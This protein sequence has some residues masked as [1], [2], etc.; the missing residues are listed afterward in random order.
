MSVPQKKCRYFTAFSVSQLDTMILACFYDSHESWFVCAKCLVE[1]VI[2][3]GFADAYAA[4]GNAAY[5]PV[6]KLVPN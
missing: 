2:Y 4:G 3:W 6:I 5:V 1:S